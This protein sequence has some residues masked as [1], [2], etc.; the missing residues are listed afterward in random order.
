MSHKLCISQ[1]QKKTVFCKLEVCVRS[2]CWLQNSVHN[3]TKLARS[4]GGHSGENISFCV[5]VFDETA[6]SCSVAW[7]VRWQKSTRY[8]NDLYEYCTRYVHKVASVMFA[9]LLST[10]EVA[11][12]AI[13][14]VLLPTWRTRHDFVSWYNVHVDL[15]VLWCWSTRI[16]AFS[17]SGQ[18][19]GKKFR[20]KKA[21][22]PRALRK[23][24]D[25]LA[26]LLFTCLV[27]KSY[28][29]VNDKTF[30]FEMVNHLLRGRKR[31]LAPD[32]VRVTISRI[33]FFFHRRVLYVLSWNGAGGWEWWRI[34]PPRGGGEARPTKNL[35]ANLPLPPRLKDRATL[36]MRL[37]SKRLS[38][39]FEFLS[40]R[41]S[42]EALLWCSH[43]ECRL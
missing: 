1:N 11:S 35:L 37:C 8:W 42:A 43:D 10:S 3:F 15:Y 29:S 40:P 22:S 39:G 23:Q 19:L 32:L 5:C 4:A 36:A 41:H 12:T 26:F 30:K 9:K 31:P 6:C 13:S 18:L 34:P 21:E 25:Q 28:C 20:F 16:S 7:G 33:R 17:A 27:K 38:L 2:R 24:K 14:F